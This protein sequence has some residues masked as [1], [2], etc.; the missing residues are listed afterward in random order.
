MIYILVFFVFLSQFLFCQEPMTVEGAIQIADNTTEPPNKGTIRFNLKTNDFE[1]WNGFFWASL[2]GYQFN[3]GTV[4]DLD[5]NSYNTVLIGSQEWMV[6]NLR[7]TQYSNGSPIPEVSDDMAWLSANYGAWSNYDTLGSGYQN[8]S[9]MFYGKY[10]NYYAAIDT[11]NICPSGWHVPTV[12]EIDDLAVALGGYSGAAIK[13][14]VT[15]EDHWLNN[16]EATNESGFSALPTGQRYKIPSGYFSN[17]GLVT[18]W[19]VSTYDISD[20]QA[21]SGG[22]AFGLDYLSNN[23]A[24]GATGDFSDGLPI[25]CIKD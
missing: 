13:M 15:G 23:L 9:E 22:Y 7:V 21:C 10:Y 8:Y 12:S 24:A 19:W 18:N 14:K 1:G 5:G 6:E 2:T 4:M 17:I 20:P 16:K 11:R 25:R 3:S